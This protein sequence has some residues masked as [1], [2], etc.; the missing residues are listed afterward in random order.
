M[1][2]IRSLLA[3]SLVLVLAPLGGCSAEPGSGPTVAASESV[4]AS[5]PAVPP[6]LV[7]T[8]AA[9]ATPAPVPPSFRALGT[10]P[11]WSARVEGGKLAWSTPELPEGVTVPVRREDAG[12]K[13]IISGKID[14]KPLEL[15]V[16]TGPCSDGMSDT[17]YPLAVTR[18]LN[19]HVEHGC[20]R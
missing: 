3:A 4:A 15:E 19:G 13:T 9:E 1:K 2:T 7:A 11:F 12:G 17:V 18:R 5:A 14:G 16:S 8:E 10:E 20:A 6:T